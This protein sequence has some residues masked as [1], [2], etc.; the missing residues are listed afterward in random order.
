M[1]NKTILLNTNREMPVIGLGVYKATG[2]NEVER[3]ICYA[4]KAGY[5]LIDT[6]SAYGNEDGVGRGVKQC[7]VSRDE[8]FITTKIWN[9][10]QRLGDIDG[11]FNR[12]LE[13]LMTDYVDLY[14]IHWPV[15]GCYLQTWDKISTFYHE[16]RA[17]SIGVSNFEIRHLKELE[18]VSDIVPAVNQIEFHPYLY[19]KELVEYC[20]SRGI[21]V[22]A[23]APLARGAYLD[24]DVMCVLATKYGKT[25]AQ[26]GLRWILQKGVAIIPKSTQEERII[27]NAQLFDFEIE[28]ED[29]AIIDTL[30]KNQKYSGIPDDLKDVPF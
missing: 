19:Q 10:A 9:N 16:G 29:M 27:N 7:S 21:A 4:T 22:Q 30:N 3:A 24:D 13:R 12:S 23:Y 26:I 20:Q 5:R 1:E 2:E 25:P 11:A 6:A 18:S 15:P 8:L 17:R 28:E 14:L